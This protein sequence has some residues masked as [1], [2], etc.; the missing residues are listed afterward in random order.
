M[1]GQTAHVVFHTVT[2]I[3]LN[4]TKNFFGNI[5]YNINI[6]F[7]ISIDVDMKSTIYCQAIENGDLDEWDFGWEQYQN[8]NVGSEKQSLL[9][10]LA[11]SK[12]I[13]LL[14]R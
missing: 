11:C 12:E 6:D 3:K 5:D 4:I 13:W 2:T 14:N 10:S 1:F 8:S 7:K 9:N